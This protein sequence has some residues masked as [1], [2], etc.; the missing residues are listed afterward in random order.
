MF[1]QNEKRMVDAIE[2][3]RIVSVSED[4]AVREGLLILKRHVPVSEDK[5]HLQKQMK[6]SPRLRGEKKAYFD[7]DKYRRP[8]HDKN[9]IL[10]SLIENFHWNI[11]ARRKQLNLTRKQLAESINASEE[12]IKMVE[13]GILPHNDYV[14]INKLEDYLK[15]NLRKDKANS[16]SGKTVEQTGVGVF[17]HEI[18]KPRWAGKENSVGPKAENVVASEI[19]LID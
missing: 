19:E 9:D 1:E 12:D 16:T 17:K 15:I 13:N 14:L 11:G 4:Y 8:W 6:M 7:I 10:A 3:G 2:D 5:E 18:R